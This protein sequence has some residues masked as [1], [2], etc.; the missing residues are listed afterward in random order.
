M[1][2]SR[3]LKS[4]RA[5][6]R[7]LAGLALAAVAASSSYAQT[8]FYW[9]GAN[10]SASPAAGGTGVWSTTNAWR[11][12]SDTGAQGTWAAGTGGTNNAFLAGTAG[13]ITLGTSGSA[14][15]TGGNMTVSTSGYTVT[16]TSNSR[17]LVMTGALTLANNVAFTID[18][19]STGQTWGFASLSL[20]TGSTL[21]VQGIATANNANRV[22]LSGGTTSSGGSMILA[23]TAAGT[24]GFVGTSGTS[25]LNTNILNNSATSATMLG[26]TSGN[27]LIYGGVL[28]GSAHLQISA[29]QSG[30]AGVVVLNN[31][32]TFTG[33]TYL[34]SATNGVTRMGVDNALTSGTTVFFGASAGG[35]TADNGGSIDLNGKSLSV[36]ALDSASMTRGVGN[37]TATLSTLTIG[38][39]T[40]SNTFGG[41]IGTVTNNNLTTQSNE[42]ALVK[43]DASTQILSGVN[44]YTGSTVIEGGTLALS[45]AG[46]INGTSGVTVFGGATFSNSST[47][48]FTSALTLHEG[49]LLAGTGTFAAN[50]ITIVADLGDGFSS[51]GLGA[52]TL[53][54]PGLLT[55]DFS[56]IQSGDFALFGDGSIGGSFT[57]VV[58]GSTILNAGN[59][60]A[61][62]DGSFSYAFNTASNSFS[63]TAVPEP[64]A[65]AAIFGGLALA[66]AALRRR[67]RA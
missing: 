58:I 7:L 8:D 62:N 38:K 43:T 53:E 24:T 21:T 35:G 4:R 59:G 60:F 10:V 12:V 29:G 52:A 31:N 26:A 40:G 13:T 50:A 16:S 28:S 66:G 51:I 25:T 2:S 20:G 17:N 54:L 6:S 39:A 56:N 36:G 57:S 1:N 27:T 41:V 49:A 65:Y 47:A 30:G 22:N 61:A 45:G 46:S 32:N 44:T 3:S 67:R 15:F 5:V 33:D 37:N 14:N 55:L 64:S 19:N 34:N 9:N 48:D 42:I 23:G 11:T 18:Q 63:I